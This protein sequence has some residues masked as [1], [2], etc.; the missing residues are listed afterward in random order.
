MNA[1]QYHFQIDCPTEADLEAVR[2]LGDKLTNVIM[3]QGADGAISA[4]A[5][6]LV[7]KV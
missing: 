1:G 5:R 6:D 7:V 4:A 3:E 2:S